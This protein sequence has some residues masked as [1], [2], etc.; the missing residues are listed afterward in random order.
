M[1][2]CTKC[3]QHKPLSEFHNCRSKPDGKF[4]ACKV[5]RNSYNKSKAKEI[6]HD[7]LYRRAKDKDPEAYRASRAAYY[8][9][10]SDRIKSASRAWREKNPERK[11]QNGKRHYDENKAQYITRAAIWSK[12]NP[13]RRREIA[14]N[15]SR[16]DRNTP[17]GKCRDASRK[18]LFRVLSLTGKRK[19]TITEKALGYTKSELVEHLESHFKDGMSWENYG[20]WHIDHVVPISELVRLGV[21]DPKEINKLSN[22]QPMWAE[23]NLSKRDR[24]DLA[25]SNFKL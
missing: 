9:A 10:N 25:M 19:T 17:E 23:D 20:E 13:E 5:C 21:N 6:G 18:M 4:S 7:V 14:A 8:R 22:L 12:Q 11:R 24:F 1:K 3:Q 15:W 16:C 2:K